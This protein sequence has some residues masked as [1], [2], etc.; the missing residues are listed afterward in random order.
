M[1][2]SSVV[3][4]SLCLLFVALH[5]ATVVADT[6]DDDPSSSIAESRQASSLP[7]LS[8]SSLKPRKQDDNDPTIPKYWPKYDGIRHVVKL[9]DGI[10]EYDQI[11]TIDDPPTGGEYDSMDPNLD[12]STIATPKNM[13]IPSCVD[14]TPPGYL[15]YRGISFFRTYFTTISD[16]TNSNDDVDD[17]TVVDDEELMTSTDVRSASVSAVTAARIQFQSCSFYCRVWINGNEIGDHRA[18]GYVAFTLDIPAN[19]LLSEDNSTIKNELFVLVDNRFNR[20][21]APMHLGG[22]F[23]HYGGIMRSVELHTIQQRRQRKNSFNDGEDQEQQQLLLRHRQLEQQEQNHLEDHDSTTASVLFYPWRLY[24]VPTSLSTVELT[25]HLW[26]VLVPSDDKGDEF[27]RY[28]RI[29][30]NTVVKNIAI[31]FDDG[32]STMYSGK[33]N[34][35]DAQHKNEDNNHKRFIISLGPSIEVPNARPWSI[36]DPQL[37]TVSVTL[38]DAT[39]IE[40]FGLR[41][42]GTTPDY[43]QITLN[44]QVIPK[45]VGWN[46]HTQY[47]E[48]AASPTDKQMDTDIRLLLNGGANFVRGAHYPQDPRWLDRLDENGLLMWSET[49]GPAVTVKDTQDSNFLYYQSQQVTEMLDN[50]MNHPSIIIWAFFNEG[51]SDV[52]VACSAYEASSKQILQRDKTRFVTWASSK[53]LYDVCYEH[54]TLIAINAYP[55]PWYQKEKPKEYWN[56]MATKIKSGEIK[57]THN[58][59]FLISETGAGGIWEWT[60]NETSTIWTLEYQTRVISEDVDTAISN[61]NISGISLWHFFDFK[62]NDET[63]NNT[64]CEYIPYVYPPVCSYINASADNLVG[65][66]G[67]LNHKGVLDYWRRTKPAYEIVA[68]KYFNISG[69]K[70]EKE[71]D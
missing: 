16:N 53:G 47:P 36:H 28:D 23:W 40:R 66:P 8:S 54:A 9:L 46:H 61:S 60:K 58:K 11:G 52:D 30:D 68:K 3:V 35:E 38:N 2:L 34:V 15:G 43:N 50:A 18:G 7:T 24:V 44:G 57:G 41:I 31:A 71:G 1:R 37:H 64:H 26:M 67:G 70:E 49:V 62:T 33:V 69:K 19:Y 42:V 13:N 32:P 20:T 29:Q 51:P 59:P 21:T 56:N 17:S 22:D 63:E 4:N 25:L 14:N 55:G 12:I 10:W 65:R 45:L 39:V 6:T 27:L 48:T 5:A